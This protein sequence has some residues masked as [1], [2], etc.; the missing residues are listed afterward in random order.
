M[1]DCEDRDSAVKFEIEVC[2]IKGTEGW[3]G[4]RLKRMKGDLWIYKDLCQKL[5]ARMK[6]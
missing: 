3:N 5:L 2:R 1:F 6:L 4:V